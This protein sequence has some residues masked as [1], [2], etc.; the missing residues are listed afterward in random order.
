[1]LSHIKPVSMLTLRYY[2]LYGFNTLFY[3]FVTLSRPIVYLFLYQKAYLEQ[4]GHIYG[5]QFLHL[6]YR[7]DIL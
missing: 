1:M 7:R 3:Q 5:K 6:Y 2:V 4:M